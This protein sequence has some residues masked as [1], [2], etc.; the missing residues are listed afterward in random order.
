MVSEEAFRY[1]L[2][3]VKEVDPPTFRLMQVLGGVEEV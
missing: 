2:L 3:L 1:L